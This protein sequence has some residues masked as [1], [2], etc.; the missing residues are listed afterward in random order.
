MNQNEFSQKR[1]LSEI[2]SETIEG[3][4][5]V[6]QEKERNGVAT[7]SGLRAAVTVDKQLDR[8]NKFMLQMQI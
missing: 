3:T 5:E 8:D 2:N 7:F 1:E 4:E 6:K